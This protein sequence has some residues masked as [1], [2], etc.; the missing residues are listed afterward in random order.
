[1]PHQ[2]LLHELPA[3]GRFPWLR[4]T[5]CTQKYPTLLQNVP[6]TEL[7]TLMIHISIVDKNCYMSVNS[8]CYLNYPFFV[9]FFSSELHKIQEIN[10]LSDK[11][12]P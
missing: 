12:V 8:M 2:L 6:T 11:S 1:M 9:C 7:I 10:I 4:N 5:H 3:H